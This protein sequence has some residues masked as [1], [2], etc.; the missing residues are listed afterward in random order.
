MPCDEPAAAAAAIL[1]R[2]TRYVQP[3]GQAAAGTTLERL[4][5]PTRAHR[6]D[7]TQETASMLKFV[8]KFLIYRMLIK[9]YWPL[10]IALF[11]ASRFLRSG[12]RDGDARASEQ[13]PGSSW[14]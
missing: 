1:T 2:A 6:D 4:V 14:T 8:F 13:V 5:A 9:R 3:P 12:R 7:M 10:A 11:L